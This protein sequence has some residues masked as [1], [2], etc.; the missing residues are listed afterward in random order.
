MQKVS[1][2]EAL[3]VVMLW[4]FT[5]ECGRHL[6]AMPSDTFHDYF[7]LQAED[8]LCTDV[9]RPGIGELLSVKQRGSHHKYDVLKTD[10]DMV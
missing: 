9:R 5:L 10:D 6:K 7:K 8:M 4:A 1:P 2:T 3:C